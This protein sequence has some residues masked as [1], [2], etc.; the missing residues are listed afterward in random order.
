MVAR[1]SRLTTR[2]TDPL[3]V[4]VS[5]T[6][7]YPVLVTERYDRYELQSVVT[8]AMAETGARRI[9]V[10]SDENVGPIIGKGIA[11]DLTAVGRRIDFL[12][13]PAGEGSKSVDQT[14]RIWTWLKSLGVERRSLLIGVGGGVVCDLVGLVAATYLR[15]LPYLLVPTSLMAQV[16]GAIGGK[17]GADFL[18]SKNWVGGFYHPVA[19][20][21]CVE[22][23]ATLT[24]EEFVNGVAEIIK[25]AVITGGAIWST[26]D[27]RDVA[28]LRAEPAHTLELVRAGVAA[29]LEL[30]SPDPY[31]QRWLDRELNFGHCLGHPIEAASGFAL[32]HGDA[33]ALGMMMA[34]RI[35]HARSLCDR[36]LVDQVRDCLRRYDLPTELP[37]ELVEPSWQHVE[38]LRQVRNGALRM[39][40]PV[41]LGQVTF[42]ADV[43]WPEFRMAAQDD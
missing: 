41:E 4:T 17:V 39:A 3:E 31:E 40:I 22:H 13:V 5:T 15:G 37:P 27:S 28:G 23:L 43:S 16:D 1:H 38:D 11:D 25:I 36:A 30:L 6:A 35:G 33:V 2:S 21:A 32:R 8:K 20:M 34:L 29:K 14:V 19:V 24:D 26:L 42:V 7:R 10:I 12:A 18:G 9:V